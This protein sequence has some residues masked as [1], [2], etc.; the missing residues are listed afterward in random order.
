MDWFLTIS[1]ALDCGHLSPIRYQKKAEIFLSNIMIKNSELAVLQICLK[2]HLLV[3]WLSLLFHQCLEETDPACPL[4]QFLTTLQ[5]FVQSQPS[6]SAT[7]RSVITR[8][9]QH[10]RLTLTPYNRWTVNAQLHQNYSIE[11]EAATSRVVN[12]RMRAPTLPISGL[13]F[14]PWRCGS[15]AVGHFSA[16]RPSSSRKACRASANCKPSTGA[17]PS[18]WECRSHPKMCGGKTQHAV[19]AALP[20]RTRTLPFWVCVAW[21]LLCSPPPLRLL[22][23]HFQDEEGSLIK[24]MGD[25]FRWLTSAVWLVFRLGW[26]NI[27]LKGSP[28]STARSLWS[29]VA[30]E[31]PP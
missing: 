30:L 25:L 7:Q 5:P 22:E 31:E 10:Q 18:C 8:T 12:M 20:V 23:R 4:P 13:L 14:Q 16:S 1:R 11:L 17:A 27:S 28:S 29:P 3:L 19:G 15:A 24:K 6:E 2:A 21:V 9:S 26:V